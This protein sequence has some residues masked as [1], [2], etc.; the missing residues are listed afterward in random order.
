M[1]H[2]QRLL[3]EQLQRVT[4]PAPVLRLH[5]RSLRTEPLAPQNHSLL[6][7]DQATGDPLHVFVERISAKLG[8]QAI[9]SPEL[10]ADHRP[11]RSHHETEKAHASDSPPAPHAWLMPTWLLA[12]PLKLLTQAQQPLYQGPLQLLHGP[13]RIETSALG[14]A[15]PHAHSAVARDYFIAWS[16]HAGLLWV[17]QERST[18]QSDWYL[19]GL[20][21]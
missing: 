16:A 12:Q 7:E 20:Y 15:Q 3:H 18:T 1:A 21:A 19:Q 13:H 9:T 11:E 8:P 4:L 6:P 2:L 17:Y 14:D 5:L 10:R